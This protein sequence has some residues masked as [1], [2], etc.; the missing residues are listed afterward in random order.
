MIG[1]E[2]KHRG[3]PPRR[4]AN[5]TWRSSRWLLLLLPVVFLSACA[6]VP[7]GKEGTFLDGDT[8]LYSELEIL[9]QSS[10]VSQGSQKEITVINYETTITKPYG[11]YFS[12]LFSR[13][14]RDAKAQ[15]TPNVIM[16]IFD[17]R[18]HESIAAFQW[19]TASNS[20]LVRDPTKRITGSYQSV[21]P[22][23]PQPQ[24]RDRISTELRT[25]RTD[26]LK[27]YGVLR[28]KIENR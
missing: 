28:R 16:F 18:S 2:S 4:R 5:Q 8:G 13:L 11:A 20:L 1:C 15:P 27:R 24:A 22:A 7:V 10:I 23:N 21:N 17:R 6:Q 12:S 26:G 25:Q 19:S 3:M 9:S 14:V